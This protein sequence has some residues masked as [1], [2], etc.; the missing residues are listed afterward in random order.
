MGKEQL[1]FAAGVGGLMLKFGGGG[2][3]MKLGFRYSLAKE[4]GLFHKF[5]GVSK[6]GGL[7]F[8]GKVGGGDTCT[9]WVE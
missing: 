8:F 3:A 1:F 7:V 5:Q 2:V 4:G 6:N 9:T